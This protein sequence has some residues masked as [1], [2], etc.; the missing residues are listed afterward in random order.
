[1]CPSLIVQQSQ[2]YKA[3]KKIAKILF[4]REES[5]R[6]TKILYHNKVVNEAE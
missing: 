4:H 3:G 5:N 6:I 1:M 2:L